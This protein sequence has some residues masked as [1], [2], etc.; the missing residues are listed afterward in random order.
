MTY[1]ADHARVTQPANGLFQSDEI[2]RIGTLSRAGLA[3]VVAR[4][5]DNTPGIYSGLTLSCTGA[6]RVVT[7]AAGDGIDGDGYPI[8]VPSGSP[9]GGNPKF[10][11]HDVG[12]ADPRIDLIYARSAELTGDVANT[13]TKASPSSPVVYAMLAHSALNHF[14]LGI[15]KGTPAGSPVAPAALL[16]TDLVLGQVAVPALAAVITTPD[17]TFVGYSLPQIFAMQGVVPAGGIIMYMGA[18][19]PAGWTR[20]D[21]FNDRFPRGAAAAAAGGTNGGSDTHTHGVS[22]I[23]TSQEVWDGFANPA[24]IAKVNDDHHTHTLIGNTDAGSTLPAYRTVVY[25]EKDA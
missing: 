2:N 11:T 21:A 19:C 24:G 6:D 18:A 3:E 25:C 5:Y 14:T 16:A 4:L 13:P 17:I 7:V 8:Y 12:D 15:V 22:T 1:A 9:S 20:V 23:T 10:V